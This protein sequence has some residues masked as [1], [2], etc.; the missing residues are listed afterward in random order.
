MRRHTFIATT[1]AAIALAIAGCSN[2][3]ASPG[4]GLAAARAR[5]A[6]RAPASYDMLLTKSCECLPGTS[7][8]VSISVRN[9]VVVSRNYPDDGAVPPEYAASFPA[10]PDLFDIID[11]AVRAGTRP[12][13]VSYDPR[14]GYPTRAALGDPAADAPLYTISDFTVR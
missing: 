13:D 3:P 2:D 7:G 12:L 4:E 10:V 5:W 6:A 1:V 9:G 8:P 14:Y 11:A